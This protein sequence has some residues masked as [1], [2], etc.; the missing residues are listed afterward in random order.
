MKNAKKTFTREQ[1][2]KRING[3]LK[4]KP[5][6]IRSTEEF[7]KRH[8]LEIKLDE[9]K[10]PSKKEE[11][12]KQRKAVLKVAQFLERMDNAASSRERRETGAFE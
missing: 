12:R 8:L 9:M 7:K 11:Y 10:D 1:L 3:L 5:V 4:S 6:P 2:R